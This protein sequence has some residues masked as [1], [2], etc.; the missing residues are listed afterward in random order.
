[1]FVFRMGDVRAYGYNEGNNVVDS[2]RL[3]L[4]TG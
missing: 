4:E 2:E 3:L 1:M